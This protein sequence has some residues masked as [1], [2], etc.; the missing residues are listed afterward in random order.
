MTQFVYLQHTHSEYRIFK[1]LNVESA[2]KN[3]Y[4]KMF[5]ETIYDFRFAVNQ[6]F[7]MKTLLF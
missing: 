5:I 1:S 6:N 2:L 4:Y 3:I 7:E